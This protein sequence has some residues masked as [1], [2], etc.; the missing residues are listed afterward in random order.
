MK[1]L[2]LVVSI[3]CLLTVGCA[4]VYKQN[5]LVRYPIKGEF[6]DVSHNGNKSE[7]YFLIDYEDLKKFLDQNRT[8]TS[9][10]LED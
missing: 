10:S 2:I 7:K 5:L 4:K 1:R 3:L 9:G 6:I 8:A